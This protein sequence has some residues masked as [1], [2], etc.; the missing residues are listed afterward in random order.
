MDI[1]KLNY[2]IGVYDPEKADSWPWHCHYEDGNYLS[3]KHRVCGRERAAEFT[4]E[5]KAREFYHRWKHAH[6]FKF[7]L[8]PVRYW[9]SGPDP[10]YPPGHPKAILKA[11]S[12]HEPHSVKLTASFW[13]YDQD[14]S[15]LYSQKTLKKHRK[16]LLKYGIDIDLP[17]PPNLEIKPEQPVIQEPERPILTIVK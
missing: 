14:I 6:L 7:E 11:I 17:R 12:E 8:I 9:V 1:L 4:T 13:F 3:V 10:V 16:T 15:K 5:Q 2:L